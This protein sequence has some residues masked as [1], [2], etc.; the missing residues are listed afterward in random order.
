MPILRIQFYKYIVPK[1]D[2]VVGGFRKELLE[3]DDV[4][5]AFLL[6]CDDVTHVLP[7][8]KVSKNIFVLISAG[9]LARDIFFLGLFGILW[10]L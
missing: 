8:P 9:K 4:I 2:D 3:T 10:I 1:F 6:F 5:L 7:D